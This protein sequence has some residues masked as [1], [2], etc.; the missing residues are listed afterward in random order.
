MNSI[1]AKRII[2]PLLALAAP[3]CTALA[4]PDYLAAATLGVVFM[5]VLLQRS[6]DSSYRKLVQN[7]Q[8]AVREGIDT[9]VLSA[10]LMML[11]LVVLGLAWQGLSEWP[12]AGSYWTLF[13]IL[14]ATGLVFQGMLSTSWLV[15][16]R[17]PIRRLV[18]RLIAFA[19][20]LGLTMLMNA[21]TDEAALNTLRARHHLLLD[22]LSDTAQVC[23]AYLQYLSG[24]DGPRFYA[25]QSLHTSPQGYFLRFQGGSIDIDGSTIVYDSRSDAWRIIH[26]DSITEQDGLTQGQAAMTSCRREDN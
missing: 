4:E 6:R 8:E 15:N 25:P 18:P 21:G 1:L 3:A 22:A 5:L 2:V 11:Y 14:A 20:A 26:N 13:V 17:L 9:L 16:R 7:E 19:T 12:N 24:Y 10:T 23:Q